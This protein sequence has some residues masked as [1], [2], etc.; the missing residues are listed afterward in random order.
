MAVQVRLS[1]ST[2]KNAYRMQKNQTLRCCL[3]EQ[4]FHHGSPQS[5][6][7]GDVD[8]QNARSRSE[9]AKQEIRIVAEYKKCS[10]PNHNPNPDPKERPTQNW[11]LRSGQLRPRYEKYASTEGEEEPST[12]QVWFASDPSI[13][14]DL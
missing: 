1:K 13:K 9:V 12:S 7:E 8:F 3:P 6:A 11:H 14:Y 5:Y 10:N 4:P 2:R